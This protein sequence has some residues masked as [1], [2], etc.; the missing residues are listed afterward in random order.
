MNKTRSTTITL[1]SL[2]ALGFTT[3]TNARAEDG[4]PPKG[5]GGTSL[6]EYKRGV[7]PEVQR[8][9]QPSAFIESAKGNA[10]GFGTMT[11][12]FSAADYVGKRV[13]F[14]GAIKTRDVSGNG[15][16]LWLRIDSA[17]KRPLG[18][19]NMAKRS[20]TGTTDWTDVSIVLDVPS[21]AD[22]IMM[23]ALLVGKGR[24]WVNSLSFEVVDKSV[25]V[26]A[27]FEPLVLPKGPGKLDFTE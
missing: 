19:D 22:V 26:T 5:W 25:A 18:F 17:D 20:V 12:G 21:D 1:L 11:K 23:G 9:G 16:G 24:M 15:A 6:R 3:L 13:R 8:N 10:E 4:P 7:D 14:K 2:V 27:K